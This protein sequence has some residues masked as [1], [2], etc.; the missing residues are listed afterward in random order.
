[1]SASA[2][3]DARSRR[4]P[5]PEKRFL[6]E[7]RLL[8]QYFTP[9]E[10]ARFV[11]EGAR[12]LLGTRARRFLD[13]ACGDGAF[14]EAALD[15]GISD[16]DGVFGMEID[17]AQCRAAGRLGLDG[18]VQCSDALWGILPGAIERARSAGFDIVAGNPPFGGGGG[19][20][21]LECRFAERFAE[22]ARPGGVGAVILP[23]G[24]FANGT[25][26][27]LRDSLLDTIDPVAVV[28]LPW[29]TFRRAGAAAR[30]CALFFKKRDGRERDEGERGGG[31]GR[32]PRDRCLLLR[33]DGDPTPSEHYARALR[34]IRG[35]RLPGGAKRVRGGELRSR[36]WDPGYWCH[37][38]A[39]LLER[40][41]VP[42]AP[43]GEFVEHITY[44]PIL[45]GDRARRVEPGP[46]RVVG[47]RE[48]RPTGLD[49][50]RAMR[51]REGSDRDLPRCR[52][53]RGDIV[54]A[55]SGAGSLLKGRVAVFGGPGP[56]TVAC[57]V[58]LVRLR[59]ILPGYA[60]VCLRSRIVRA[61]VERLANGVGTPNLS[62]GEIRGLNIPRVARGLEEEIAR[63]ERGA[64]AAHARALSAGKEPTAAARRLARAVARLDEVT[65]AC[66]RAGGAR[67]HRQADA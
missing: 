42:L 16:R 43:L 52:L 12:S 15:L 14:L 29:S 33:Y 60:V 57:F 41:R 64:R 45:T 1:V 2:A 20:G 9:P 19:R 67:P 4:G 66:L 51:V 44:G 5:P 61:Q 46:V 55:R 8:G 40:A 49:L 3:G 6:G 36:R 25:S 62:F 48:I 21:R 39:R 58:D 11:L 27:G 7:K 34:A 26:R 47:L 59:G 10:T 22:L 38:A 17:P 50:R 56:A 65:L 54:L 13:P 35:G 23:T 24:V 18:N 37:E 53:K 32:T 31:K 28:E 30:T 63:E